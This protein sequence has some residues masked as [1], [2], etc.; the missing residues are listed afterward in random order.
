MMLDYLG[1]R[2]GASQAADAALLIESAVHRGFSGKL[3]RPWEYGGDQGTQD[4]TRVLIGLIEE[5]GDGD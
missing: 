2:S 3:L 5:G 1:Q 4:V